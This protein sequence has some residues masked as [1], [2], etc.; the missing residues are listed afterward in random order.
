[1][2]FAELFLIAVG[3]A[4]DAFAISIC[5][6]L[7]LRKIR[8][9]HMIIPGLWFGSFQAL[10]PVIGYFIGTLFAEKVQRYSHWIAFVLLCIIGINMIRES[11][12]EAE[13]LD[14]SMDVMTMLA[15]AVA[16][17][18]DAL[19]VGTSFALLGVRIVPAA[20]FIGCVTFV[21]SA[22]GVRIGSLFGARYQEKAQLAGGIILI[23]IGIKLV[24]EAVL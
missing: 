9:I 11:R 23:L 19:A 3:L 24:A 5:K 12:E 14:G 20:L 4:M 15:L 21:I 18:I 16:T 10:M 17:S 8:I 1:M 2:T 6:G 7:S 13:N 22:A